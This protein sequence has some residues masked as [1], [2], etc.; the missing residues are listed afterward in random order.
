MSYSYTTVHY[1]DWLM[2]AQVGISD[3]A[4]VKDSDMVYLP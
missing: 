3:R 4:M 1:K 2:N